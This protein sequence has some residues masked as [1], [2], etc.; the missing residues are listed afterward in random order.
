MDVCCWYPP[1]TSYGWP[2]LVALE[3]D[4][5][6]GMYGY[7]SRTGET[8]FTGTAH[9]L[10]VLFRSWIGMQRVFPGG[11]VEGWDEFHRVPCF[12]RFK[13]PL[14]QAHVLNVEV[15]LTA[16]TFRHLEDVAHSF[17]A[18]LRHTLQFTP[19]PSKNEDRQAVA[20]LRTV[21]P[22]ASNGQSRP[23]TCT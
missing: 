9:P 22:R 12:G 6:P 15:D 1:K 21:T 18:I 7:G 17:K 5:Q 14:H 8:R 20:F 13:V 16:I 23:T 11:H 19:K 3:M 10:R 2:H 4:G